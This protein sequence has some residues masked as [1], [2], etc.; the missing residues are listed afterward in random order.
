MIKFFRSFSKTVMCTLSV[1]EMSLKKTTEEHLLLCVHILTEIFSS[2]TSLLPFC[3]I[4]GHS[5]HLRFSVEQAISP[6]Y[7]M[8]I[9]FLIHMQ[10]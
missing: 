1:D 8:Q 10:W 4:G 6:L 5:W 9:N 2:L 3:H 7:N